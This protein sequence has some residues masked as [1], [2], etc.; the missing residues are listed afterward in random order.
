MGPSQ[1]SRVGGDD[2]HIVFGQKLSGEEGSVRQCI[3]MMQQPALLLPK[4]GVKSLYIFT[5][6]P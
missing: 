4:F 5:Q 6:S 3:V 1:V 2:S